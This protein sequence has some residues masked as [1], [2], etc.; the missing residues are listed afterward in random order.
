MDTEQI[1]KFEEQINDESERY[2]DRWLSCKLSLYAAF[3][4]ING[5]LL[6]VAGILS[7]LSPIGSHGILIA[8]VVLSL[9]SVFCVVWNYHI[10]IKLYDNLGF[11]KS[12]FQNVEEI[13]SE[14]EILKSFMEKFQRKKHLRKALDRIALVLIFVNILLLAWFIHT[15][16]NNMPTNNS[17][18]S[19]AAMVPTSTLNARPR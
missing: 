14:F 6:S 12:S 19:T 7:A 3:L 8:I 10:F 1:E 5:M 18:E 9:L 2:R 16:S 13:D 17:V 11:R 15:T 4:T